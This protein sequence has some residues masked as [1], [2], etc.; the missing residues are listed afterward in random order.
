[1]NR[2]V[3]AVIISPMAV[4]FTVFWRIALILVI[5]ALG[6]AGCDKGPAPATPCSGAACVTPSP[7]PSAVPE[8][9]TPFQPS[10][11]PQ[12]AAARVNG[13]EISLA[14]FQAEL[15][16]YQAG[17]GTQLATEDPTRVLNDLVDELLLAEAAGQEGFVLGDTGLQERYDRLVSELGDVQK[18]QAWMA[19]NGYTEESFR[20]RLGRAA[21][22]AWMRDRITGA[23]PEAA[24][25][26]HARQILLYNSQEANAVLAQ[27]QAGADFAA[28]AS[29]NDPVTGGDLGWF[30]KGYLLDTR[31]DEALFGLQPDQITPVIETAAGFHILQLV[32]REAQRPLDPDARLALQTRALQDWLEQRRSQSDIQVLLP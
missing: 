32:E 12:P 19:A 26:V 20:Q 4:K 11:T 21:A 3:K 15:A 7:L 16:R 8:T 14:D 25:Q 5:L 13:E 18:L 27:L 10:P 24:E 23:V 31:L 30:P 22:A 2:L 6:A 28:L 1:M 9:P 29:E 17:L